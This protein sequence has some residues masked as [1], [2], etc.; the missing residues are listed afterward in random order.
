[1]VAASLQ[2]LSGGGVVS[3]L[4][5]Y[6]SC[7]VALMPVQKFFYLYIY[8]FSARP[9]GALLGKMSCQDAK[10]EIEDLDAYYAAHAPPLRV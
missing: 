5:P 3:L 10:L 2:P 1:M 7:A 9:T 6:R 4:L 8:I